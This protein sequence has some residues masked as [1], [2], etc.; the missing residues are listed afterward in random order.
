MSR[1]GTDAVMWETAFL[2]KLAEH[3]FIWIFIHFANM[4]L[5]CP[6]PA[7]Q[8]FVA[9]ALAGW[10]GSSGLGPILKNNNKIF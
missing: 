7:E 8:A 10:A 6:S 3:F 9:L 5:E 1:V 4:L 2:W